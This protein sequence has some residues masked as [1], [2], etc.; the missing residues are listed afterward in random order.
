MRTHTACQKPEK[1]SQCVAD[2]CKYYEAREKI[3]VKEQEKIKGTLNEDEEGK[4]EDNTYPLPK[5]TGQMLVIIQKHVPERGG[6]SHTINENGDQ[7]QWYGGEHSHSG[8][9]RV[10]DQSSEDTKKVSFMSQQ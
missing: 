9:R 3:S 7:F 1:K 10:E 5:K 4:G 6:D 8:K 2:A